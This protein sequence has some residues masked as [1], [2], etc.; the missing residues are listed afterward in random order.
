MASYKPASNLDK[1]VPTLPRKSIISRS[2]RCFK[3]W[4]LRRR[5][6][7]PTFAPCGNSAKLLYVFET[8]ASNGSSRSQITASVN[9]SGNAIGTSFMECTAKSARPSSNA[10]S[11]SF[12]NKPLPP[13]LAKGVSKILSPCVTKVTNSTLRSACIA[14]KRARICSACHKASGLCRVAIFKIFI[15]FRNSQ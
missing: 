1:R 5:L 6:E 3:I 9:P 12:T 7:V 2:G 10:S 15:N 4:H 8:K 13:I 14:S 11:N